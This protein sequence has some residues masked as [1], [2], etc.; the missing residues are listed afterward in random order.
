DFASADE[1]RAAAEYAEALGVLVWK[2]EGKHRF[3]V[4]RFEQLQAF[5]RKRNAVRRQ[6][7]ANG[8]R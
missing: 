3:F 6:M 2:D 4:T 7:E 8:G 5:F 1:W